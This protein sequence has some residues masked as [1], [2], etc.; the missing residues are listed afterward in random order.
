MDHG[1]P[2]PEGVAEQLDFFLGGGPECAWDELPSTPTLWVLPVVE[3]PGIPTVCPAGF[4]DEGEMTVVLT[5]PDGTTTKRFGSVS[6]VEFEGVTFPFLPGARIGRYHLRATAGG[7]S[8]IAAF[9]VRR[10]AGPRMWIDPSAARWGDSIDVYIGGFPSSRPVDLHLYVCGPLRYRATRSVTVDAK[11]E[12]HLK[13][14]TTA[15]RA[16]V[17]CFAM[18]SPLIFVPADPPIPG[19]GPPHQVFTLQ[20]TSDPTGSG[21]S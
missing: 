1:G 13:L 5:A 9:E 8:A 18:N 4:G 17:E 20:P 11:G 10:A 21:S 12:A 16:S 3:V 2:P 19:D 6:D 7:R 15:G 14:R